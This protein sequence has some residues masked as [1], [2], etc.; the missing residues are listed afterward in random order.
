MDYQS[1]SSGNEGF[2]DGWRSG[3]LAG[4]SFQGGDVFY[5]T[6]SSSTLKFTPGASPGEFTASYFV[7][8]V[9]SQDQTTND[10]SLLF[11]DGSLRKFDSNGRLISFFSPG[12][13]EATVTYDGSNQ[14]DTVSAG[15]SSEGWEYDYTWDSGKVQ[16]IIYKV[17][18]NE[19]QKVV[20][21]YDVSQLQTIKIYENSDPEGTTDWGT[22]PTSASAYTYHES[23]GLLKH[24]IPPMVY[25][26]MVN[27]GISDPA[28]ATETQLNQYAQTRYEYDIVGQVSDVW[29][30][31]GR[32]H[33]E[34]EYSTSSHTAGGYN[35]WKGKT[36]IKRP[37]DVREVYYL[38]AVGQVILH[39]RQ[40]WSGESLEKTW[41]TIYQRFDD[42]SARRI[43]S[44]NDLAIQTVNE[45]L[46]E[47]V[48]MSTTTGLVTEYGYNNDGLMEYVQVMEGAEDSGSSS[49]S[50]SP[51]LKSKIKSWTYTSHTVSG[52]GTIRPVA[53]ETVYRNANNTGPA[54]TNYSYQWH[55]GTLQPSKI[56][57]TL[58]A[59]SVSEHGTGVST[60]TEEHFDV[61]GY[62][63]KSVDGVG[64]ATTYSYDKAKGGMTQM[65]QDSGS[66]K[67][68]LTTDYQLDWQSRTTRALGP[69]H[70]I[71]LD[72][73]PTPTTIRR[74]SWTYYKDREGERW[75]LQGYEKAADISNPVSYHLV[76][77][78]K[79]VRTNVDETRPSGLSDYRMDEE[80][81]AVYSGSGLP[82]ET[83]SFDSTFPRS[84]W[85]SWGLSFTD[86]SQEMTQSF[87]YWDIPS[88]GYGTLDVNYGRRLYGYDASGRQNQTTCAG[89][90]TDKTT[91]NAMGWPIQEELGI[92]ENTTPSS[93]S[94]SASGS[95]L[96]VT[97]LREFD[98]AG[99]LTQVT[100]PVDG[101]TAND[102]VTNYEYDFRN[103]RTKTETTVEK[104][105]GGTW[106]LIEK[107]DYDNRDLVESVTTYDTSVSDSNRTGYQ[108]MDQDDLGRTYQTSV[109]G[110]DSSG[111]T[112]NPQVSKTWYDANNRTV[113]SL[114]AG[115]KLFTA[116]EYDAIGRVEVTYQAYELSSSSS[117]S[118]SSAPANPASVANATVMEQSETTYDDASNVISTLLRQR[119]DDTSG[120]GA[121]GDS[122]STTKKARVTYSASYPD[123]L[124]RNQA[125]VDYGTYNNAAWTRSATIPART[126]NELVTSMTYDPMSRVIETTDPAGINTAN[127]YDQAGRLI[128]VVENS[129]GSSSSS[130]SSSSSGGV[131]VRTTH[132]EYTSDS[133]LK[134]LKSDNA[135]TGQQVTEWVYGVSPSKGS[136]LYS[137]R[138]V[139]QKIYPDGNSSSSSSSSSGG[140]IDRVTNTFNR[141]KQLTTMTDQLGTKHSYSYDKLG[142]LLA[143]S[144]VDNVGTGVD[145][146]V[147]KLETAYDERGRITRKTSYN[148]AGTTP[149]NEVLREYNDFNQLVTEYQ[150]D[151]GNVVT[152]S[153]RKVTYTYADGSD[154]TIRPTSIKYPHIQDS[155]AT[156]ITTAYTSQ[157][158]DA[159]SRFDELKEG[160]DIL[161]SFKYVGLGMTVAQKYNEAASTE[162]TY[163]DSNDNYS[164]Y[165]RFGRIARTLW[166]EGAN[167]LVESQYEHNRVGG[168]TWRKDVKAHDDS[169]ITQDNYYWYD[170]LQQVKQHERG[171]LTPGTGPPYTGIDPTT[172][173]QQEIF[174]FDETGNWLRDVSLDPS[175]DQTRT[176]NKAN[177][178]TSISPTSGSNPAVQPVYDKVGNMTTMPQPSDWESGYDCT[179]DAW[180]R[181]VKI[182]DG[183]TTVAEYR[184]D[185]LIRRITQSGTV[186]ARKYYYN[187]Q[188]R[189]IEELDATSTVDRE[190]VYNPADRWNL[191]RRKYTKTTTLD[192][193]HYVLRDFLDPVAIVNTS[194]E[195]EERYGYDAFGPVRYMDSDFVTHT[196]GSSEHDW[197]W[198]FHG[199]F[200]DAETGLYNYGYR[201]YHPKLGRWISRDPLGDQAFLDQYWRGKRK[202]I[203]ALNKTKMTVSFRE[204]SCG[205]IYKF[206][207]NEPITKQDNLGLFSLDDL[208][209]GVP[210]AGLECLQIGLA[211][212]VQFELREKVIGRRVDDKNFHCVTSCRMADVCGPFAADMMGWFKENVIDEKPDPLDDEANKRGHECSKSWGVKISPTALTQGPCECCCRGLGF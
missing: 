1:D 146:S 177:E 79:V 104:D 169:V 204:E 37:E 156:T 210:G 192:T 43:L 206:C 78:V 105:G 28:A 132:Y 72:G 122:G 128:K 188:W 36:V 107:T 10:Y 182:E 145:S 35:V 125:S 113:K 161:S 181:L 118:S 32:Y 61:Q 49:S 195:V 50:S 186:G 58:P 11:T 42:G 75:S 152:T 100:L 138:L 39:Q 103:R 171:D 13:E 84:S 148:A 64:T 178:I 194:G 91:F 40:Q 16:S 144:V 193:T 140:T 93:S 187:K 2:G 76:G 96:T 137:N 48:V 73:S 159:L 82:S 66:G 33:Y 201:Y 4:L 136:A 94:S 166:E 121:L 29:T 143:D 167:T 135:N 191:I 70:E 62:L 112:S 87:S 97:T 211:M 198:L 197:N 176:H 151:Q 86:T 114:P 55:T 65:V 165:D 30:N 175:L 71:D 89:N 150:A 34:I 51:K 189:V 196:S 153:S 24:V 212:A 56:T 184:Y 115:S 25:R 106:T 31:G 134:K 170:G 53:S 63:S 88:S 90:T 127:T 85:E 123:A 117:S 141:Q 155:S 119:Y 203:N 57:T 172:R 108:T 95:L 60:T 185:A 52:L 111:N 190:Y 131:D 38:N 116:T 12:G 163:G 124:G 83:A 19:I 22:Q 120:L 160:S 67:L 17:N 54:T 199:E 200:L 173:Q 154:N 102:R 23:S 3:A 168:I 183:A 74:A 129:P 6:S 208:K 147:G 26:Q 130:S 162:L 69:S 99:N 101:T 41:N 158:A 59:V 139:Y 7:R 14:V 77:A 180:N 18:G 21:S 47:L 68:N 209:I 45:S 157:Q 149:I 142:R 110:V 205:N 109:Y 98:D 207:K 27:N 126:D 8:D 15:T 46:P 202:S 81:S 92:V 164:G 44:A 174:H 133:W 9:L 20:F 179:W 80:V 5:K